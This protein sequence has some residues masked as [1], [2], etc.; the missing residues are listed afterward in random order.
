MFIIYLWFI[1]YLSIIYLLII[2]IFIYLCCV[3]KNCP[4]HHVRFQ[5]HNVS[6]HFAAFTSPSNPVHSGYT[7]TSSL[8]PIQ[9]TTPTY[10][11]EVQIWHDTCTDTCK[12]PTRS[13]TGW[14][15]KVVSLG[16]SCNTKIVHK[17]YGANWYNR[18]NFCVNHNV[19]VL[20]ISTPPKICTLWYTIYD[21]HKLLHVSTHSDA[22][23][24]VSL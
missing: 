6:P 8:T 22:F 15:G 16:S 5:T 23:F 10:L 12:Q 24:R 14:Q 11:S 13:G 4:R 19:T 7:L 21:V 1:Y 17:R 2:Y 3:T 9:T 18:T 20:T